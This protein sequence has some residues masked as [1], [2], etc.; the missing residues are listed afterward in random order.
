MHGA[1]RQ[2]LRDLGGREI[3]HLDVRQVGDGAAIVARAARLDQLE[4]GALEERL[5]VLLQAALGRHRDHERRAHFPLRTAASRSIQTAKPTAGIGS[6]RAEPREQAVVAPAGDQLP[7]GARARVVELEHEAGVVVEAAAEAGREA[8]AGDVDAARGQKAGAALEQ[9]E[10][11]IERDAGR[12]APARAARPP[13][14]RDRRRWRGISRSARAS[15]AGSELCAPSADCSRKRSAI[16]P[17]E[18]PPTAVMPAI[19]SRSVTSACAPFGSEPASAASTPWYSGRPCAAA[20]MVRRSRSCA[21]EDLRLKSLIRRRF[22]AGARSSAATSAENSAD[23]ADAD[24]GLR[25]PVMRGG[26]EPERQHLGIGRRLV[27]A[28]ERLDAGLQEFAR[29]LVRDSGRPGRDSRSP[30][31]C[32]PRTRP[33]SRAR[34]GW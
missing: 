18:R 12:R 1:L 6:R 33:D 2:Q 4:P 7:G 11:G 8:D 13:P 32:R 16:S 27:G 24:V 10:R 25:Q 28:A 19:E 30:R 14:R 21:S 5:G 26:V 17:T 22:Q 9:V 3:G 29:R 31:P 34:P 23:V 15:R 20:A